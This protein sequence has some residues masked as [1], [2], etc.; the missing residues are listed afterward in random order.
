MMHETEPSLFFPRYRTSPAV[1]SSF[2]A[3]N[4]SARRGL[5]PDHPLGIDGVVG[6]R[7]M[8]CTFSVLKKA[9]AAASAHPNNVVKTY[10][11]RF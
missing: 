9:R 8:S 5:L 6:K 4:A 2:P 11:L 1:A 3:K 10:Q 7:C